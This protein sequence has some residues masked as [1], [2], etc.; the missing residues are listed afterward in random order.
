MIS[1]LKGQLC[2]PDRRKLV[3]SGLLVVET[4]ISR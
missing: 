4:G 2:Y 1:D 3:V